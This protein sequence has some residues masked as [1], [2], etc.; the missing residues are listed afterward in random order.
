LTCLVEPAHLREGQEQCYIDLVPAQKTK[1]KGKKVMTSAFKREI[2]KGRR[3]LGEGKG[4]S[5]GELLKKVLERD[6]RKH[7]A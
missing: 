6:A 1:R 5:V 3:E 7:A 2:E 4:I